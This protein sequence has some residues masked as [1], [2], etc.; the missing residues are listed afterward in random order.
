MHARAIHRC[1]HVLDLEK[2]LE[3]YEKALGMTVVRRMGPEDHSWENV[4]IAN[5]ESG[6][7]MELTWNDGRT[8]PYVNGGR[9]THVCFAVDDIDAY[10]A[11][12]EEMGVVCFVNN[13]MG[14]YF[15][16]DPDGCWIEIVANNPN[17]VGQPGTDVLAALRRRH[18]VRR[19]TDEEVPDEKLNAIVEAGLLSAAGRGIRPWELIVVRNPETLAALAAMRVEGSA[20]ML[21]GAKAAI[22][23]V[24]REEAADTWIEDCSICMANMHLEADAL[25]LG[26]CWI[27]GRMRKADAEGASTEAY[28]ANLLGLPEGYVLEAT[29]S[30]GVPAE[31]KAPAALTDKLLAKVHYERF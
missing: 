16:E 23:V 18:S 15:I 5:E 3:F 20:R 1:I 7:Q 11:L 4:F 19:Y 9:D 30:V 8:E 31:H 12:H 10:R 24:A 21:L 27:Q 6:F 2:S 28:V 13:T 22:V 25:G 17:N 14:L 26:S 29:L